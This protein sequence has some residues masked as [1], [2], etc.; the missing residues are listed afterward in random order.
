MVLRVGRERKRDFAKGENELAATKSFVI[1]SS[2]ACIST[3]ILILV[4]HNAQSFN[5][6]FFWFRKR[7]FG[8]AAILSLQLLSFLI[9]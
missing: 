6:M 1:V 7:L 2:R 9:R 3:G 8:Y 4:P 5:L